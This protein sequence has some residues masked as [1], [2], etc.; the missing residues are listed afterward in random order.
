MLD[1]ARLQGYAAG[2]ERRRAAH[3]AEIR[4]EADAARTR[5]RALA[6]ICRRH[7]ARRVRLFGSLVTHRFGET[8]DIDL[9]VEGVP[10][11][12]FF[13][14]LAELQV[15]AAPFEVDLIDVADAPREMWTR[16]DLEGIDV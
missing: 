16:I 11:D 15:S 1:R 4:A 9:A 13:D 5:V 12:H 3:R 14:L 10:P 8:P 2:Y 6:E 7:G